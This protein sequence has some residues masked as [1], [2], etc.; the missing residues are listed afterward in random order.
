[1]RPSLKTVAIGASCLAFGA[2]GGAAA[3]AI[4]S[5]SAAP[6]RPASSARGQL[7]TTGT[8]APARAAAMGRRHR[9]LRLFARAVE[10][11]IEV[12][13]RT[14]FATL[15]FERGVIDSIN[16]SRLELTE[17]TRKHAYRT[18]SIVI[19]SDAR[20]RNDGRRASLSSLRAGER[21]LIVRAPRLTF[22]RAHAPRST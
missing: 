11:Q 6:A 16:G 9:A 18:V 19:P 2:G 20:V 8:S 17:G 13:T 22:V 4:T 7:S 15:S 3:S 10:G 12:R 14:G 5:A 1:M 21:V